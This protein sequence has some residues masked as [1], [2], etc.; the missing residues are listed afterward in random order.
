LDSFYFPDDEGDFLVERARYADILGPLGMNVLELLHTYY[1]SL[2]YFKF[3]R[4][5]RVSGLSLYNSHGDRCFYQMLRVQTTIEIA[6]ALA[7]VVQNKI[8]VCNLSEMLT[9]GEPRLKFNMF[10]VN[11]FAEACRYQGVDSKPRQC[12]VPLYIS[13]E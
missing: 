10:R 1:Y 8:N 13:R 6:D 2:G 4:G 11:T 9:P 5:P 3:L 12:N 7:K